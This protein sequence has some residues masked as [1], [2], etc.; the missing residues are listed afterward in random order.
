VSTA[1]RV[2][3]AKAA[4]IADELVT[5]LELGCERIE[6]AGSIRRLRPDVGDIELVAIPRTRIDRHRDGLFEEILVEVNELQVVVDALLLDGTLAPH[7][8]DPKRGA[9]Y[10][11]LLHRESGLQLDLFMVERD[12]FGLIY[13]IRTG[14][15]AYSQRFV[16]DLHVIGWHVAGGRLHRGGGITDRD[17][18][19]APFGCPDRCEV[20]PTPEEQDVY[21]AIGHPWI[22][23]TVRDGLAALGGPA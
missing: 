16:T 17:G 18:W 2:P 10:A 20:V 22:E 14:P 11:K 4:A 12:R 7:P 13:L 23:P 6:V 1:T 8:T 5:V 9:R 15:A 21:D 3:L 19:H